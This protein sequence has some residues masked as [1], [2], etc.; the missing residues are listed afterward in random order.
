MT[1]SDSVLTSEMLERVRESLLTPPRSDLP[2]L[3]YCE[4][5][6]VCPPPPAPRPSRNTYRRVVH[7][8]E[9]VL[10]VTQLPGI[11]EALAE[12]LIRS[13][14]EFDAIAFRGLSGTLVAPLVACRLNKRMIAVRKG[15]NTHSSHSAE[16]LANEPTRYVI[17][18]DLIDSGGTVDSI[19][20]AI[21]DVQKEINEYMCDEDDGAQACF[22]LVGIATYSRWNY[23]PTY[24]INHSGTLDRAKYLVPGADWPRVLRVT[25]E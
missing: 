22:T 10:D 21:C 1:G 14:W 2:D 3:K 23:E 18:D 4:Q 9:R 24:D 19:W 8:L 17:V 16:G 13:G 25:P 6:I 20:S 15:E 5:S 7:Y 11:A 12:T